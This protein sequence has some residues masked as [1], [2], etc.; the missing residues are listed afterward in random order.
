MAV[1]VLEHVE[2]DR[3]FVQ[4]VHRVLKNGGVFLMTTPNGDSVA[5]TNPDHKRHY[6]RCQLIELLSSCFGQVE[7]EY[8]IKGG[9]FRRWGLRPW[10]P[11][12]PFRTLL[13]MVGNVVNSIESARPAIK[14]QSHGTRHLV[15]IARK[16]A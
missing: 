11:K 12:R 3:D 15:A 13:G 14:Q 4:E 16:V 8:A 2:R 6:T 1:E 9:V 5:N 10:S 7:V